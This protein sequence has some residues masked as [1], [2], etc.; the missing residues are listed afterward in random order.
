MDSRAAI[1]RT[2]L[3]VGAVYRT[4][5]RSFLLA[6]YAGDERFA[7]VRV[8]FGQQVVDYEFLA[9][10]QGGTNLPHDTLFVVAPIGVLPDGLDP[11]DDRDPEL[12]AELIRLTDAE[13]RLVES[14]GF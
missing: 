7:G 11:T 3:R 12:R 10:E 14:R 6:V 9:R 2:D 5:G 4:L 13:R 8:E 1:T